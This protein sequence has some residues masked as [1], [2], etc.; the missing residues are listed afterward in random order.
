M[1]DVRKQLASQAVWQK[2]RAALTWP[3]KVR[4]AEAVR[5]WAA[6]FSRQRSPVADSVPAPG[7]PRAGEAKAPQRQEDK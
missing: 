7:H 2:A 1:T 3:E 4:M 5:E 6:K